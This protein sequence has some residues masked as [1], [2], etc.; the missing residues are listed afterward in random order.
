MAGEPLSRS[1]ARRR[2]LLGAVAIAANALAAACGGVATS[3]PQP[4]P[5]T[6]AAPPLPATSVPTV[7]ATPVASTVAPSVP[8]TLVPTV[9]QA[10]QP[11]TPPIA[12]AQPAP[13]AAVTAAIPVSTVGA[14]LPTTTGTPTKPLLVF[15]GASMVYGLGVQPTETFPA[16]TIALLAPAMYDAVNLG[17]M[18][19]VTLAELLPQAPRTIDPLYAAS[20]SKNIIVLGGTNDLGA[21]ASV[22]E[23]F[24][25]MVTFCQA[26]RKVGFKIVALTILPNSV[27][28]SGGRTYENERQR[29]NT[30]IRT[31]L[32]TLADALA[33]VSADPTIGVAG[34]QMNR[35]YFQSDGTHPTA[36]AYSIVAGIVKTAILTLS[37][38]LSP[39]RRR[40]RASR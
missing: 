2:V 12:T 4:A 38:R 22:D 35:V 15:V 39:I 6:T 13:T 24:A 3:T 29:Y 1:L 37:A 32:T 28:L 30:S 9:S 11:T 21:G 34:A 36:K 20:R 10:I 26:R 16:Q 5:A 33:D 17:V 8:P 23:A 19:G 25:K 31:N 40:S 27:P 18:G 14:R 7:S